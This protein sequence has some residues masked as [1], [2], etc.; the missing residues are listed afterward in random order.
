M[1]KGNK[2]HN[3]K[4]VSDNSGNISVLYNF[5]NLTSVT[6]QFRPSPVRFRGSKLFPIK[7][8]G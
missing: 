5:N 4:V 3:I 8:S 6:G 7:K 2:Y 1:V